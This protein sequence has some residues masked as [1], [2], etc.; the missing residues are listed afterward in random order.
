MVACYLGKGKVLRDRAL[1]LLPTWKKVLLAMAMG[2]R[3]NL[4][5]GLSDRAISLLVTWN[6]CCRAEQCSFLFH[7]KDT[8]RQGNLATCWLLITWERCS[9]TGQWACL[10]PA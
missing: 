2:L 6:R 10:L 5:K 4:G 9:L 7:V 3:V 8:A 1:R